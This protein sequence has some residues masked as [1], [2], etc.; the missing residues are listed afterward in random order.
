[1]HPRAW[2]EIDLN[3]V[4]ANVV[5]LQ[6]HLGAHVQLMAVVKADAYGHG[7]VAVAHAALS[8]GVTWL[9]VATVAEG[10]ALRRAGIQ[11]PVLLLAPFAL[12][13][14]ED[15][16][17]QRL[18]PAVGDSVQ[19]E[20]LAQQAR[21]MGVAPE[22][23]L[24][25]DTGMGRAGVQP[26]EACALYQRAIQYGIRVSGLCT[27][28]ADADGPGTG[29]TREQIRVFHAVRARLEA[30][31]ARFAYVHL[32]NS[33]GIQRYGAAGGNLVRPGLLLYGIGT[34]PVPVT[35]VLTLK[36]RVATVRDLP[37]GA[38]ISYGRTCRLRRPGRVATVLIGYGDGYSRRLSN[39]GCVLIRG[40][41]AP[42]LGRVCMDQT[43]VDVTDVPDAA[44]GDE[45]V[46]IGAQGDQCLTVEEI[47]R[48]CGATE[49]EVSTGLMPRVPRYYRNAHE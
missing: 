17:T 33:A 3:A 1:M 30:L 5:A 48:L 28:F 44:P 4:R 14:A 10:A 24:E 29:F 16:V 41:R 20:A 18:T 9:G 19:I 27:H 23:H 46:C 8:A 22:V 39:R 35:P 26:E 49:H 13:E 32:C 21:C 47:A 12:E 2:V 40:R 43:V 15:L 7:A 11:A 6:Q 42:V 25:V 34:L 37:A 36:A 31:G 38:N 45:A